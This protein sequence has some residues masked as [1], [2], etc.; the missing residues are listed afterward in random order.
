MGA[1][2]MA[3]PGL[4]DPGSG[5]PVPGAMRRPWEAAARRASDDALTDLYAAHWTRK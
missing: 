2:S 1:L 5:A 3:D 4:A